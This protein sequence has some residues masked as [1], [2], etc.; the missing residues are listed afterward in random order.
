MQS[1]PAWSASPASLLTFFEVRGGGLASPLSTARFLAASRLCHVGV[2]GLSFFSGFMLPQCVQTPQER[3]IVSAK[4]QGKRRRLS[5]LGREGPTAAERTVIWGDFQNAHPVAT[6]V[7]GAA[8]IE[9]QLDEMIRKRL[10]R[11]DEAT[12]SA[13]I[14]DNGPLHSFSDKVNIGYA[15]R[16]YD[17]DLRFDLNVVRNIVMHSLIR[18]SR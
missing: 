17:D 5:D 16:I 3:I 4:S 11:N 6:A 8:L 18:R 1:L 13:L 2:L 9:G 15:L 10:P 14:D 12:W 7:L